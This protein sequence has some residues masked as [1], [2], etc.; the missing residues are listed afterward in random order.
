MR[1][2]CLY[3]LRNIGNAGG[4]G[5]L[6]ECCYCLWNVP[7]ACGMLPLLLECLDGLWNV[8]IACGGKGI[9]LLFV[10][11]LWRMGSTRADPACYLLV[12]CRWSPV[13]FGWQSVVNLN[14]SFAVDGVFWENWWQPAMNCFAWQS[15]VFF[16]RI[17]GSQQ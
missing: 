6:V 16:W 7:S 11:L 13:V 15:A 17:G 4:V 9:L 3:S 10:G 2:D 1:V 5:Q 8:C 14:D 12:G